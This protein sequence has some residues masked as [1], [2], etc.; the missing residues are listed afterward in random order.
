MIGNVWEWCWDLYDEATFGN[1]RII[2]GG[3]WAEEER[4]CGATCRRKSMPDFFISMISALE[5]LD[6]SFNNLKF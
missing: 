3:S 5:L 2:R 6:Q 1:Y 4:G